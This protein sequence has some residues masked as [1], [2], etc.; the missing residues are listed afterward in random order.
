MADGAK[1]KDVKIAYVVNLANGDEF[2][3]EVGGGAY[4]NGRKMATQS[5]DILRLVAFDAHV[6]GRDIPVVMPL[7]S[8]SRKARSFG[9]TALALAYLAAGGVSIMTVPSLSRSFDF[10]AGWLLVREAGGMFTDIEGKELGELE[11]G[12]EHIST[13]LAAGNAELHKKALMH[14]GKNP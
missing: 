11:L 9:S 13:I 7:I 2:W 1:L 6:P 8:A 3:A 14:L 4:L 12:L 10:A 5:D